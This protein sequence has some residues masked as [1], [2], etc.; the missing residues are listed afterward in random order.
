MNWKELPQVKKGDIG[1]QIIYKYLDEKK[2]TIYNPSTDRSHPFD[3]LVYHNNDL[4]FLYDVKTKGKTN[5]HNAQG[6]DIKYYKSYLYTMKKYK[7]P[8]ILFFIDDQNGEVHS[9]DL[10]YLQDKP[11]VKIKKD[12]SIVGWNVNELRYLFTISDSTLKELNI[13]DRRNYL[14]LHK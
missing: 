7:V 8:F 11:Y 5:K 1:E 13:F 2:Y 4:F 3:G 10:N 9:A 14:Y 6:I 12:G